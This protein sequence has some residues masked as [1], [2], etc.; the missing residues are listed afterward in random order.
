MAETPVATGACTLK[1]ITAVIHGFCIKI[2]CLFLNAK[3]GWKGLPGTNT[4]AYYGN[5][6]LQS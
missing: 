2:E 1:L 4:L 5:C 3:V 6:K